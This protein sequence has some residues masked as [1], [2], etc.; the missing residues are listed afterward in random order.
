MVNNLA[1][2]NIQLFV[3]GTLRVGERL[4]FYMEGSTPIGLFFTEG[5]LMESEN[6]SAYIDFSAKNVITTG[7]V[8]H[9]NYYCLQ[10][11]NHLESTWNDFPRGYDLG[12]I[13]VWEYKF[14]GTN[15][16][17]EPPYGL[18]LCYV[19]RG[20]RK[21]FSGDWTKR[22]NVIEKIGEYLSENKQILLE[23]ESVSEFVIN[24]FNS[25]NTPSV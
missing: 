24:Y 11:I 18:A 10:R 19:R 7:E 3:F 12:L 9:I 16:I 14:D 25:M 1:V 8:H 6:G 21:V 2:H 20:A 5:Q 13:P 4:D 15:S 22:L 23:H 17:A